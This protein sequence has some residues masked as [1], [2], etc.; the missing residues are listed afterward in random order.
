MTFLGRVVVIFER[1]YDG[2]GVAFNSN[3]RNDLRKAFGT[4]FKRIY[5]TSKKTN[6][7]LDLMRNVTLSKKINKMR[8]QKW[9]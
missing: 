3:V 9:H 1:K 5:S 8:L 6:K 2:S 4:R 7:N